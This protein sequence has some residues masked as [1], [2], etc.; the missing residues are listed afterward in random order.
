[1]LI[2]RQSGN[3]GWTFDT[4]LESNSYGFPAHREASSLKVPGEGRKG[5]EQL[6]PL[7]QQ[8][9]TLSH[10]GRACSEVDLR[11]SLDQGHFW[12]S[13][14]LASISQG[15]RTEPESGLERYLKQSPSG[16]L[17]PWSDFS[18]PFY[19]HIRTHPV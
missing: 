15:T 16:H 17:V 14:E 11:L 7:V 2:K 5:N 9:R 8:S 18:H 1:M 13:L 3:A 12:H 19:P 4:T 6:C 10:T